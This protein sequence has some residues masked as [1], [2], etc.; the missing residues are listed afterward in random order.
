MNDNVKKV[1]NIHEI[2]DKVNSITTPDPPSITTYTSMEGYFESMSRALQ[3]IR[4]YT[5]DKPNYTPDLLEKD[6][7]VLSAL[8]AEMSVMVGYL[9]GTSARSETMHKIASAKYVI[10]INKTKSE[11]QK[12]GDIVKLTA[13]E[14][15]YGA[16]ILSEKE[17]LLARDHETISRIITSAWYAIDGHIQVLRSALKRAISEQLAPSA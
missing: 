2:I 8:H 9:Q 5:D 15:R 14:S 11:I 12:D 1:Y 10:E 4:S 16:R 13:D 6:M 7:V 17:A 3:I